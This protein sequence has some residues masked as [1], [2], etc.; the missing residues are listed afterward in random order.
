MKLLVTLVLPAL[1]F[2][3][4][5]PKP[6]EAKPAADSPAGLAAP[7]TSS[8]WAEVGYR[9]LTNQHGSLNTYR[10]VVNLGEGPRLLNFNSLVKPAAPKFFDTM[11]LTGGAWGDP[12]NH[13]HLTLDKNNA[14][15]YTLHYRNLAYFNA[16]PS[17][18]SPQLGRLSPDA[19]TVNQRSLDTRQRLLNMDLDLRPG[20]RLRPFF[21]LG[22]QTGSGFGVSPIVA[23]ENNY[24]AGTNIDY[25]Y[26]DFRGGLHLELSKLHLT[27]E[28][29]GA[30]FRDD[31]SL[32]QRERTTGNRVAPI[33]GQ[34]LNLTN[35]AQNYNIT[36]DNIYSSGTLTASPTS[37]LDVT[38]QFYYAR[39]RSDIRFA[40]SLAG[41]LIWVDTLRFLNGQQSLATGF[42]SQPRTNAL[43]GAEL[44][45]FSRIRL[46]E[47]L[48]T[49]RMHN[50][51]SL[52]TLTTLDRTT[53]PQ[54]S[55]NDRL[56]WNQQEQR[57][58]G[59]IE[60]AR[61]LTLR[62]GHR[63]LWGDAQVRSPQ[64]SPLTDPSER[65]FLRRHSGLFGF[66]LRPT[67]RLSVNAD[68]EVGRGSATYFRTSLQNFEQ[69]N[70]R[71]RYQLGAG[72]NLQGRYGRMDNRNPTRG[73]D[74]EFASQL[75]G[76]ATQWSGKGVTV[77]ADYLR[78]TIRN[79]IQFYEPS[80]LR[81]WQSLY[82]D[83]AHTASV[84]ADFKL[85][86]ERVLL[87]VGGTMLRTAGSRPTRFYQPLGRISVPLHT[88]A[89]LFAEW[90]H[91]S[92]GQAL[93]GFEAFGVQQ[94][95]VGLRFAY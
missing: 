90:R 25:R 28:Q 95:T 75:W 76:A 14:Y 16:L 43:F 34:Q 92:M 18:A 37:F 45:P 9:W 72:W 51:A 42:A 4:D 86:R 70:T 48:Q 57:A 10:S 19:Y 41:T 6:A 69:I 66:V 85:P 22:H 55:L 17:F 46:V 63:Y 31:Q 21:G 53:L 91:F 30:T 80:S 67:S 40:E 11:R 33:L 44:R 78:S 13:S 61:W 54:R 59:F 1:L 87:T 3:Q 26:T 74:L 32:F 35:G 2:A 79:N 58:E 50:A 27:L 77:T 5:P 8:S 82:R 56:V 94:F 60:M 7:E 15:R 49:D 84:L 65:G 23:D 88:R 52:A 20:K 29:G 81:L 71:I 64:L 38:G 24:A 93:Y 68:A 47:S 12:F 62:A 73:V 83:N 39:P 89:R 36:G